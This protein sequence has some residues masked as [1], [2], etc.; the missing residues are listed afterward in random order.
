M[1]SKDELIGADGGK[2]YEN[3]S[4]TVIASSSSCD[5]YQGDTQNVS[6]V[7]RISIFLANMY[8]RAE[9]GQDPWVS[10]HNYFPTEDNQMVYG[11]IS[12]NGHNQILRAHGGMDVFVRKIESR[13]LLDS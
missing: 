10:I 12:S 8:K 11:E 13:N 2:L 3:A 6:S 1:V 7:S 5:P 9:F 4:I